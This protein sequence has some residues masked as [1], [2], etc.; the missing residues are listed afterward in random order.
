MRFKTSG[1]M[2]LPLTLWSTDRFQVRKNMEYL[3][4]GA[5]YGIIL[6]MLVYNLFLFISL[7]SIDYLYYILFLIAF[8]FFQ[9]AL[10]GIGSS[11][12]WDDFTSLNNYTTNVFQ[13]VML[14]FLLLFA[15]SFLETKKFSPVLYRLLVLIVL[16]W[17][18][19]LIAIPFTSYAFI[20]AKADKLNMKT[21]FYQKVEKSI[22]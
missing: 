13:A 11:Y 9:L 1:S 8:S 21:I 5:F 3:Y 15:I 4:L 12:I 22:L 14:I 16:V 6:I 2:T 18:L 10:G 17:G 20:A 19:I 7:K